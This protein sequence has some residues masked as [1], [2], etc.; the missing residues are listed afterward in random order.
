MRQHATLPWVTRTFPH[1]ICL[2][3]RWG[4]SS[5]GLD[6]GSQDQA[7]T[8]PL[9]SLV[10]L[11]WVQLKVLTQ[12]RQVRAMPYIGCTYAGTILPQES[13][14][15]CWM[16]VPIWSCY[17]VQSHK[18][19]IIPW[20]FSQVPSAHAR[21][22]RMHNSYAR[23]HANL[24]MRVLTIR[25]VAFTV[26]CSIIRILLLCYDVVKWLTCSS[27]IMKVFTRQKYL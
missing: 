17:S 9:K 12:E 5:S 24:V 26:S 22:F 6:W 8:L 4:F 21:H 27:I 18:V 23:L 13:I 2:G 19:I 15:L 10:F 7:T 20:M 25:L 16:D 1:I 11:G 3:L 14:D